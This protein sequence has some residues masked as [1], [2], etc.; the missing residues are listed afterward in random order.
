MMKKKTA[1]SI[2]RKI[3]AILIC[4]YIN[5]LGSFL[6]YDPVMEVLNIDTA[7]FMNLNGVLTATV[8]WMLNA[9]ILL[10]TASFLKERLGAIYKT[11]R[12]TQ[13]VFLLLPIILFIVFLL[14]ASLK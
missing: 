3:I 12:T 5:W 2:I 10:V 1:S 13:K 14:A 6:L 8:I 4:F 7:G 9:I 11:V